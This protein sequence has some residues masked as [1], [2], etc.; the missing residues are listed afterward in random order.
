MAEIKTVGVIGAGTMGTGIAQV[1]AQ[2]GFGVTLNDVDFE[3]TIRGYKNVAENLERLVQ[4]GKMT[5][6]EKNSI[7]ARISFSADLRL[8]T[9]ADLIIEAI[10]EDEAIKIALYKKLEEVCRKEIIFAT[11]TS[12]I[13]ITKL[14]AGTK[15]PENFIGIHFMN[16]APLMPLIEVIKGLRTSEE[17]LAAALDF[18]RKLGK[19]PVLANDSPGFIVN[20]ILMPMINEAVFALYEGVADAKAI[21]DAMK[22]GT[23]QPMGPLALAD[24]IGL[25]ICLAIME[26]LHRDFNDSKYRPC[27]LLKK[28]VN[29]GFLGRKTGKGFYKYG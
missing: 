8:L 6:N 10:F 2:K 26:T 13:S 24:L 21:D 22:L 25:D 3:R 19:T 17:T 23:N 12:S 15:R 18:C 4:K 28:Y 5:A 9:T 16:P 14:A 7:W 1:C 11:N 29:A 27:P 20:R